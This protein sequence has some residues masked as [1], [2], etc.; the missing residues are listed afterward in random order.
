M[1]EEIGK[2]ILVCFKREVGNVGGERRLS[3]KFDGCARSESFVA[4]STEALA[5]LKTARSFF[6]VSACWSTREIKIAIAVATT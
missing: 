6:A 5:S 4:R 2:I 1:V 3:R